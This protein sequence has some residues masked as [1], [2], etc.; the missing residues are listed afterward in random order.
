MAKGIEGFDYEKAYEAAKHSSELDIEGQTLY[1][2][3]RDQRRNSTMRLRIPAR[4]V[5]LCLSRPEQTSILNVLE[6]RVDEIEHS[7][8]SRLLVRAW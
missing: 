4:D 3:G 8:E 5:S 1:V 2:T 7:R 6:T